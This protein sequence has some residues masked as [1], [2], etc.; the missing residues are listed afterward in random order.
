M[1][2]AKQKNTSNLYGPMLYRDRATVVKVMVMAMVVVGM[3][4]RPRSAMLDLPPPPR[5][6]PRL[7]R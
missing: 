5:T 6:P 2:H 4:S 3:A 1:E 7:Q